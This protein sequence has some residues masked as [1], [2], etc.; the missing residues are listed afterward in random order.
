MTELQTF[1]QSVKQTTDDVFM[2][3][4]IIQ[5][6]AKDEKWTFSNDKKIPMDAT[7]YYLTGAYQA[8]RTVDV[9]TS[10]LM[11]LYQLNQLYETAPFKW[12]NRTYQ[13]NAKNNR[14]IMIDIESHASEQIKQWGLSYP[15][16]YLE[17]SKNNGLHLLIQVPEDLIPDDCKYLFELTVIKHPSTEF[18]VIFN[19]HYATFTKKIIQCQYADYVNNEQHREL[20][21]LFLKGLSKIKTEEQ[22]LL[23]KKMKENPIKIE[24][25]NQNQIDAF[26]DAVSNVVEQTKLKAKT[27]HTLEKYNDYSK[28]EYLTM[29]EISKTIYKYF[30]FYQTQK[31]RKVNTSSELMDTLEQLS[32]SDYVYIVWT[33]GK[34]IIPERAKH[35]ELRDAMP[36]LLYLA[37]KA[38]QYVKVSDENKSFLKEKSKSTVNV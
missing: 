9:Q 20:L 8:A 14:T 34:D 35:H 7:F 23:A 15:C 31:K 30:K 2:S 17:A 27:T 29:L 13:F 37:N 33:I 22:Y 36:F 1:L 10:P 25:E 32:E 3:Y 19:K 16:H 11:N 12:N 26:I 18:E 24:P 6:L 5:S 38:W 28:Y 21:R 4:P